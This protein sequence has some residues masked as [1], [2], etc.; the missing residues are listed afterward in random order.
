MKRAQTLIHTLLNADIQQRRV[1]QQNSDANVGNFER[2]CEQWG[3]Q[4]T[5]R[6]DGACLPLLG[7]MN[8]KFA[9]MQLQYHAACKF[10]TSRCQPTAVY[11]VPAPVKGTG[12]G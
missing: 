9:V 4:P 11:H 8:L 7:P 12:A 2:G 6:I 3:S 10:T 1:F 5:A